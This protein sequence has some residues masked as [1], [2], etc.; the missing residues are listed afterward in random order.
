MLASI[1]AWWGSDEGWAEAP[2]SSEPSIAR[3]LPAPPPQLLAPEAF[4]LLHTLP[5]FS[6]EWTLKE[7]MCRPVREQAV[8]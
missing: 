1:P 3:F 6:A 2:L 7:K 5:G 4:G 8:S